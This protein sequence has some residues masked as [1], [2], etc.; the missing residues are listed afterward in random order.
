MRQAFWIVIVAQGAI[1]PLRAAPPAIDFY[2]DVRPI[3]SNT[4][5]QC[6]GPD[7]G[8][9][10]AGL[11][12]DGRQGLFTPADSGAMPVVPG[13]LDDSELIHRIT[14]TDESE[15]MPPADSVNKL[16]PAQIDV[17]KRWVESGA[18]WQDHWA[19]IPPARPSP[20][21]VQDQSWGAGAIDR[22]ILA[23]LE[24]EQLRPAPPADATT[25]VRRLSFDLTGLPPT[26]G[27]VNSLQSAPTADNYLALVDQYLASEHFGERMAVYWLD[28]VRYA[29]S[30]G[31]HSDNPHSISP[32]RDYVIRAFNENLPFDQFTREQLA[33]DLLPSATLAQRVATGFNRLDKTTE[34]G[35]AQDGEY[36]VKSAADRVRTV[37][38][39][40]LAATLGCAECHDHKFDP[41]TARDFY[42]FAAFFADVQGKGVYKAGNRDPVIQAPSY[43]DAARVAQLD[44]AIQDCQARVDAS[45]NDHAAANELA[46]LNAERAELAKRFIPSMVTVSVEPREM[47]ILPRG[48]WLNQ[49]GEVV[50]PAVP[51]FLPQPPVADRRLTRLDLA[52]WLVDRRHPLTARVFVNRLW[53]LFFGAGLARG[54]DDLGAQGEPPTHPELLDWLAV[55]FMDSGWDIKHL[56]RMIVAS[57][58]YQQSSVPSAELVERDPQNRLY[59]RQSRWRLEAEFIRDVA[60][61]ASGLL[62]PQIGGPSVKPY[63]PEGYWEFLNFPKRKWVADQG[64]KQYRRGLYTHWQRTFLHP[65]LLAFDAS[66][67]EECAAQRAV[68]NTPK[69]ALALLNDPSFVEAAKALAARALHEGG[70]TDQQRI[71]WTWREATSRLP[72]ANE[73][74]LLGALLADARS[75]YEAHP[76][77]VAL[78]LAVGQTPP[79]ADLP[80]TEQASW[81][82]VARAVLNLSEA[83][84]RN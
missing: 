76:E 32:Y 55:E 71:A 72:N 6:H 65:S 82:A 46:S 30:C 7:A 27:D 67:R 11:R 80:P 81:T 33:G 26:R 38:G 14:S 68:S 66:T 31:Y 73:I 15:R 79:A 35:G 77:S 28:L 25:L 51:A 41:Y 61:A 21:E 34:E 43:A 83:I 49:S 62:T 22:F 47:R 64:A 37:A 70:A 20:P 44:K 16:T 59:A 54:L 60:L 13:N 36:L 57:N 63:Q 5:Y 56:V 45:G 40:W 19:Y 2:R 39:V 69:A 3:L 24:S 10:E 78:V 1:L 4:C 84:T 48:D 74:E 23:R 18:P 9:R 53:K 52:N 29:D 42:S 75:A 17:L 50:L 58:A 8:T 12:L